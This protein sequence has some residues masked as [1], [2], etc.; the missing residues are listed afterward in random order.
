MFHFQPSA[1]QES[2]ASVASGGFVCTPNH[3]AVI[4]LPSPVVAE[5]ADGS[6]ITVVY[7]TLAHDQQLGFRRFTT[8]AR[9]IRVGAA[10]DGGVAAAGTALEQ[11]AAGIVPSLRSAR[12]AAARLVESLSAGGDGCAVWWEVTAAN[13]WRFAAAHPDL[14]RACRLY[15]APARCTAWEAPQ[16]APVIRALAAR[17]NVSLHELGWLV[18]L[19]LGAGTCAA[20]MKTTFSV[21]AKDARFIADRLRLLAGKMAARVSTSD[22]AAGRAAVCISAVHAAADPAEEQGD[23][24]DAEA[25]TRL[26]RDSNVL[27]AVLRQLQLTGGDVPEAAAAQLVAAPAEFRLGALAGIVDAVGDCCARVDASARIHYVLGDE[28]AQGGCRGLL[29][30]ATRLGRSVGAQCTLA[31]D[32]QGPDGGVTDA[33]ASACRESQS[34][35]KRCVLRIGGTPELLRLGCAVESKRLPQDAFDAAGAANA[36]LTAFTVRRLPA[37][38]FTGFQVDAPSARFLMADG[39]VTHN[40]RTCCAASLLFFFVL[41]ACFARVYPAAP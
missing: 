24:Q 31:Q 9:T 29:S 25:S 19:W 5:A 10:Q 3:I 38:A 37:A 21:A 34:Q 22:A 20:A 17:A 18:G 39:V 12:A 40:C 1:A 23:R 26:E 11:G 32:T 41:L 7:S 13:F 15:H 35:R 27:S 2:D 30:L 8:A 6:A 4:Q 16:A 36:A 33:R 28:A 14:A